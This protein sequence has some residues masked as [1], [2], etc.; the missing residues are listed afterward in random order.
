[1]EVVVNADEADKP[2]LSANTADVVTLAEEEVSVGKRR[3]VAGR[4]RL[5]TV[6][7][8]ADEL[9]DEELQGV[10]AEIERVAVDRL[11]EVGESPPVPRVEG[12]VTIVPVV[13]EVLVVEKRLRLKEEVHLA[14]RPTTDRVE[15]S[16]PVRKQRAVIERVD[17]NAD[18]SAPTTNHRTTNHPAIRREH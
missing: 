3:V 5:R 13:E 17:A 14:L 9:V 11:L 4:V 18:E 12:G 2:N 6:T 8:V 1:M 15:V 10:R 7:D 16:V